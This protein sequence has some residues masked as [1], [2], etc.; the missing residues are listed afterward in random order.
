METIWQDLRYGLRAMVKNPGYTAIVVLT[1]ALGIGANTAMFSVLNTYL[2]RA[3]PYPESDRLVRVFRTSPHSQSWPHS[4]GNFFDHNEKNEVFDFMA[5]YNGI[6]PNFADPGEPAERLNGYAI[7]SDFFYALGVQPAIGRVFSSEEHEQGADRVAILSNRFW[8]TRYGAD[9]NVLGRTMRLDGQDVTIVGV[10]PDGFDHPLLWGQIDIWRPLAFTP[11]GRRGRGSNYLRSLGRL[12]PGV[13]IDQAQEAMVVLAANL[14]SEHPENTGESLRLE[15]LSRSMSDTVARKVMWFTFALSGFV[16]LIACANLANLQLVRT[17]ARAR[18]YAVRAALGAGRIRLL[19]QSLTES[20]AVSLIGGA[21]SLVLALLAVEFISRRLFADLPGARVTLDLRVFGF[22]L[23]CSLLTGLL[24]GTVPAWLASR[25]DVNQALRQNA[26]GSTAGRTHHRWRHALIIGEVAFALVLL[27]GA[28]LFLLGLQRFIHLDPGWRVDGLLAAQISLQGSAYATPAQRITFVQRFEERLRELPGVQRV[29]ISG[30]QAA[31]GFN[32]SG[33]FRVEGE[34][35]PQPGQWP[36]VFFE[37]VTTQYFETLEAHLL[38]GRA[39]TSA[40]TADSTAVVIINETMAKR[41]WPGESAVGKRIGRPG[42]D[43]RWMQIVGVVKDIDFPAN[44]GEPYTR[45]Q[46][47]RPHPQSPWGWMTITMRTTASPEAMAN[48]LR[49]AAADIDPTQPIHRVRTVRNL[50]EQGLGNI[51]LLG[52]LL[53]AFAALGLTLSAI[54][55]FGVTSYSVVQRT[56]EIGIRMALGAKRSDVLWLVLGKGTKVILTGTVLGV[57][58]AYGVTTLLTTLIPE[59][60]TRDLTALAIFT[61]ALIAVA[62]VAC[63]LPARRAT[64]VD[65]MVALRYE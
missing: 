2:F 57:I 24:F 37:P 25:A 61:L 34:P 7:T 30:S 3:L 58:G 5:A 19:R 56:G 55:I 50:V 15:P 39:F 40:D 49:A 31:W 47:F 63:Y 23:L 41:F 64:K 65:P 1:L 11:E 22:T 36:E 12:K 10:M 62:L 14:A 28:G 43:P 18:E 33:S 42:Q 48:S 35:E 26:R 44:L 6:G 8:V 54:G 16:L 45:F 9:P 29:A 52:I 38:E 51:S 4:P 60:P 59:L 53:G 46:A 21:L 20:L 27:A 17:A 13:S 32:S